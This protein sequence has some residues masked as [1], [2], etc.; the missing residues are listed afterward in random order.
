MVGAGN[1]NVAGVAGVAPSLGT[2][3]YLTSEPVTIALFDPKVEYFSNSRG[4][5]IPAIFEGFHTEFD[6]YTL[7][8]Q[9]YAKPGDVRLAPGAAVE[10]YSKTRGVWIT[11]TMESFNEE[12]GT[13]ALDVKA[14]AKPEDV[15]L[16][17]FPEALQAPCLDSGDQPRRSTLPTVAPEVYERIVEL[18]LTT[19]DPVDPAAAAF[20]SYLAETHEEPVPIEAAKLV[21]VMQTFADMIEAPELAEV[22]QDVMYVEEE[23]PEDPHITALVNS[24]GASDRFPVGA[25][26]EYL[27]AARVG[28][29]QTSSASMTS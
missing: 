25:H 6:T 21:E 10:Y 13:Y 20:R 18:P 29:R 3:T 4:G 24:L 1:T 28:S 26:M 15:R 27:A 9:P 5:W 2:V 19:G 8:V 16:A 12:L 7:D 23:E 14:Y 17:G 11:A 22:R